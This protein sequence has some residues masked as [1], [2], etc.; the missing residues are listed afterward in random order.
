MQAKGVKYN[1]Y[2]RKLEDVDRAILDGQDEGFVKIHTKEGTDT[3]LGATIVAA[4]AGNM[5][6]EVSVAMQSGMG[7]GALANVIHPYPTQSEAI[8]QVGDMYNRGKLTPFVKS[9][10]RN[11]LEFRR[12]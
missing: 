1:T 10:F 8:R 11:L 7:L 5:I 12:L 2:V 9:V 6:S 3:I 4:D